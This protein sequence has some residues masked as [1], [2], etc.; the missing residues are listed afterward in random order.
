L[1]DELVSFTCCSIAICSVYIIKRKDNTFKKFS[2]KSTT[3]RR[4]G[5]I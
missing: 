3:K 5:S 1:Q 4:K 2:L